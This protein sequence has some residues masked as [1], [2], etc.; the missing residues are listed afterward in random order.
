MVP[1]VCIMAGD[2]SL[3]DIIIIIII[4]IQVVITT[5]RSC[6][7]QIPHHNP[8]QLKEQIMNYKSNCQFS[9]KFVQF[10]AFQFTILVECLHCEG[11]TAQER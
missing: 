1:R 2:Y 4:I 6:L 9:W 5:A 8:G 11:V 3:S 7:T 10:C